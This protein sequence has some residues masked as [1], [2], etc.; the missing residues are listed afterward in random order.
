MKHGDFPSSY[1]SLPGR[2]LMFCPPLMPPQRLDQAA[3]A[4]SDSDLLGAPTRIMVKL[5]SGK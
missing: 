5:P 4:D 3:P 2:V 1:V